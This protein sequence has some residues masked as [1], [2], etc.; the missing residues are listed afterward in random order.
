MKSLSSA[1][2]SISVRSGSVSDF[3]KK[4][5][6][7]QRKMVVHSLITRGGIEHRLIDIFVINGAPMEFARQRVVR[8]ANEYGQTFIETELPNGDLQLQSID[9]TVMTISMGMIKIEAGND[10]APLH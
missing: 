10:D 5:S 1:V 6:V 7:I 9:S 3:A 4:T 2:K 8:L